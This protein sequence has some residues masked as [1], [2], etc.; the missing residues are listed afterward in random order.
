MKITVLGSGDALGSP[1]CGLPS[2]DK[3]FRFGLLIETGGVKIIIDTNPDLKWQCLNSN[4]QL[5]D[6]DYILLTHTHSDHANG[7]GEFF[8]RRPNPIPLYYLDNPLICRHLEYFRYLET[9]KVIKFVPY[10]NYQQFKLCNILVTPLEL[11]HGFP[12]SGFVIKV[13]NKKIGIVSDT[14]KNLKPETIDELRFCDLIFVDTF[15]ENLDQVTKIYSDY[16]IPAPNLATQ[17]FHMTLPQ[18]QELQKLTNSKRLCT[19]H[20]NR[21]ISPYHELVKKY[22]THDFIIGFDNQTFEV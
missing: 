4:F 5:K 14:N 18:A 3:R 22:Q 20:M 6:I 8:Y 11:N 21:H 13:D 16:N 7:M 10:Q 12:C 2:P 15:S 17:W 19:V 1:L 9:E